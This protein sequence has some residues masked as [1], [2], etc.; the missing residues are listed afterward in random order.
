VSWRLSDT[1]GDAAFPPDKIWPYE[2]LVAFLPDAAASRF[3]RSPEEVQA[4]IGDRL[5]G[6]P[7]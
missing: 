6:V 1:L 2:D 7:I 4:E 3:G 5:A